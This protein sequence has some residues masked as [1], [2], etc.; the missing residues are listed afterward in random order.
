MHL[1]RNIFFHPQSASEL[2]VSSL[3]PHTPVSYDHDR[4]QPS[5]PGLSLIAGDKELDSVE[6]WTSWIESC[7]FNAWGRLRREVP[8]HI[9]SANKAPFTGHT[10]LCG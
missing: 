1:A 3:R 9:S 2:S 5:K 10:L 7:L 8:L 4:R 6:G